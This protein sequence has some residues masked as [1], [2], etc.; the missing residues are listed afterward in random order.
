MRVKRDSEEEQLGRLPRWSGGRASYVGFSRRG[1]LRHLPESALH[2]DDGYVHFCIRV[3]APSL[4]Q[5]T[6]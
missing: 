2:L 1:V 6:I 3:V 5:S 4:G